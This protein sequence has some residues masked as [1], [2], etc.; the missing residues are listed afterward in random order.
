[1]SSRRILHTLLK[2]MASTETYENSEMEYLATI[3]A[4][5]GDSPMTSSPTSS[6]DQTDTSLQQSVCYKP[7]LLQVVIVSVMCNYS[8]STAHMPQ[9]LTNIRSNTLQFS[10][11]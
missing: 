1:M 8:S 2:D 11:T 9:I 4:V 3:A 7:A 10:K 6:T 5:F